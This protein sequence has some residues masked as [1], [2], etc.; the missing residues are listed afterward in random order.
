MSYYLF[1]FKETFSNV[2]RPK[3]SNVFWTDLH[4]VLFMFSEILILSI[5]LF[6]FHVAYTDLHNIAYDVVEYLR[7]IHTKDNNYKDND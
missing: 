2:Q 1:V 3:R 5:E 6:T 4:L 7:H